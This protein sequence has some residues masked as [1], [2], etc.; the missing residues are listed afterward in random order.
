MVTRDVLSWNF[1][2]GEKLP[3]ADSLSSWSTGQRH[4]Y[5]SE[6]TYGDNGAELKGGLQLVNKVAATTNSWSSLAIESYGAITE[7]RLGKP[8]LLKSGLCWVCAA[9]Y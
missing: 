2:E 1:V 5:E 9:F 3:R 8:P 4:S 7:L 6:K